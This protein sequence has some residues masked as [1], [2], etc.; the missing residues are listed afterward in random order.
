M[1]KCTVVKYF[2]ILLSYETINKTTCA[3]YFTEVGAADLS[4]FSNTLR[5]RRNILWSKALDCF[6]STVQ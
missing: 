6:V 4:I 5:G 1:K 3:A 2:V